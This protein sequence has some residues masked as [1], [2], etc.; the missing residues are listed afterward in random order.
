VLGLGPVIRP[1]LTVFTL[2]FLVT[3]LLGGDERRWRGALRLLAWAL[4][5]PVIYQVFRMG[6]YGLLVPN[7]AI[8][9]EAGSSR[10]EAG[11]YYL[12]HF[13]D[14]YWLWVP[15][16]LL[17]L[18]AYLPLVRDLRR[19]GRRRSVLVVAAFGIGGLL[20]AAY[21]VRVGGDW[22]ESRLLLPGFFAVLAPVAVVP[23]R[24]RYLPAL[25]VLP[26]AVVSTLFLRSH[27]DDT[28]IA[29]DNPVGIGDY[30][31]GVR[32]GNRL[33]EF[34]G[35]G[36]YYHG[37]L[38][39]HHPAG[40]RDVIY[41]A[42]GVGVSAFALGRDTYVFDLLGLADP[43]TS[44][45]RIRRRALPG[46]EKPIPIPWFVA[47]TTPEGTDLHEAQFPMFPIIGSSPIDDPGSEPFDDR[48]ARARVVLE[49][50]E[51]RDFT[52]TYTAPLTVGRFFRNVVH[53]ASNTSLRIE[54][55]PR[56]AEAQ[57]CR[58]DER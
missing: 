48:V 49:C 26:W 20:H 58:A 28:I 55:E 44:H 35:D 57:L 15:L 37:D 31:W 22:I 5:L 34:R 1:E 10:W 41:G 7:P 24:R 40:G 27:V 17:A 52:D 42:F 46:H 56:D 47:R 12:R 50:R 32:G 43:F 39:S 36:V 45:L 14:P 18:G 11:W 54:P 25:A 2:V 38:I 23:V 3:V 6:Y 4:A 19:E 29:N 16:L 13:V 53:A 21:I 8:A 33:A 51:L 30:Q 9:K